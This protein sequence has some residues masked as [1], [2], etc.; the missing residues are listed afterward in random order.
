M[1]ILQLLPLI[2]HVVGIRLRF[3]SALLVL[4]QFV[5]GLM[6]AL[7]GNSVGVLLGLVVGY[8]VHYLQLKEVIA[9]HE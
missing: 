5:E 7:V 3:G 2:G 8:A 9:Q 4:S 1:R 6:V